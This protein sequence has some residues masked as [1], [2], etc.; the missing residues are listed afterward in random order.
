M[1]HSLDLHQPL[2]I[3]TVGHSLGVLIFGILLVLLLRDTSV[4]GFRPRRLS[5]VAAALAFLWN[6]GSLLVLIGQVSGFDTEPVAALSFS[7]LS[8]L[9]AVLLAV[10]LNDQL[11]WVKLAG[12]AVS[13][14]AVALHI[15]EV[16]ID[17]HRLHHAALTLTS[18]GFSI[19]AIVTVVAAPKGNKRIAAS[20]VLV[21]M[22]LF[23][24]AISFVHFYTGTR[25][26]PWSEEIAL[27]HAGIPLAL[28]VLLQDLRFLLLD[29]YARFL[30]NALVAGLF[31]V[32]VVGANQ[33]WALTEKGASNPVAGGL[34]VVAAGSALIGFSSVRAWVQRWLTHAV[35]RRPDVN[36]AIQQLL[37]AKTGDPVE[38]AAAHIAAFAGTSRYEIL[39]SQS[40]RFTFAQPASEVHGLVDLPP[41]AEAL[42]PLQFS[43]GESTLVVLGGR[44]GGRRYLSEELQDLTRLALAAVGQIERLRT[45]AA[46]RLASEAELKALQSQINP[47]FLFNSLNALYGAI[48]RQAE[49]ARKTVLN[50]AEVFRYSL[51]SDKSIITVADEV[52]IVRAYLEIEKLRLGDRLAIEIAVDAQAAQEYIPALSIQPLVENAVKHGVAA[53]AGPGWVRLSVEDRG[54]NLCV[55]VSDSG[56]GFDRLNET[57]R[58][59]GVGLENVRQRLRLRYGIGAEVR[60][61]HTSRGTAV[62]FEVPRSSAAALHRPPAEA[63]AR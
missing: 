7:A 19:L 52:R 4:R 41:W 40:A 15:A 59:A 17:A 62:S 56:D 16:R 63:Q 13:G 49:A 10:A 53:K 36:T 60:I 9:P 33:Q 30:A 29:V 38:N 57:T 27:H 44:T 24:L 37:A 22:C 42:V 12:V 25:Y 47:H 34:L 21:P 43:N 5:I 61:E 6:A 50:L 58:G 26:H 20:R 8:A 3:N 14:I 45:D 23:L 35:F 55:E 39:N 2:L 1:S 32:L 11:R 31:T 28:F 54:E 51:Q 46:H 48:P 18:A